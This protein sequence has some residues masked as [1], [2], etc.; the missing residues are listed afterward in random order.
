MRELFRYKVS[1]TLF[2]MITNDCNNNCPQ[3]YSKYR[4]CNMHC[5]DL[6]DMIDAVDKL[7]PGKV[8]L[9][10]GE[11]LLYPER[12]ISF[13]NYYNA[14]Y[15]K[16]WNTTLCTNL[17][18]DDL[19]RSQVKA[20]TLVD[21][22]QT[23]YSVDRFKT[24]DKFHKFIFNIA[25]ANL[26]IK[27]EE[28]K[29][30][31]VNVT[32]TEEQ[33]KEPV[34]ELIDKLKGMYVD[35]VGFEQLSYNKNSKKSDEELIDF[36]NRTDEYILE[37]SKQLKEKIPYMENLT[38]KGWD[39]ALNNSLSSL[40][41]T[42]CDSGYCKLLDP[43]GNITNGCICLIDK[44]INRRQKFI[45]ECVSCEYYK[46]CKMDCERF[47]NHCAFPKKTFEYFLKE[48]RNKNDGDNKSDTD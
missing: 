34:N 25:N 45:N 30:I 41:C 6:G 8:V 35:G 43:D 20:I 32:I 31:D 36:Y 24:D 27:N 47:G 9:T 1:P 11:P 4:N 42:V 26:L 44:D 15:R 16:H 10:G 3:C 17:L 46:Y 5:V 19:N 29:F 21:Y 28:N 33:L 48:V 22:I 39:M 18:F 12:I 14:D 2:I 7:S 13:V 23:T 40:N 37:A 38:F